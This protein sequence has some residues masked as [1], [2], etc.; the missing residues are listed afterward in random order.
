LSPIRLVSQIAN[1]LLISFFCI[2]DDGLGFFAEAHHEDGDW[3]RC[4]DCGSCSATEGGQ[5]ARVASVIQA[6]QREL[7]TMGAGLHGH[8]VHEASE[9]NQGCHEEVWLGLMR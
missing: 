4:Y 3:R 5:D 7:P 1:F 2:F 8:R 6:G 9:E